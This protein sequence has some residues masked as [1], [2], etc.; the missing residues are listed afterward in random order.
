MVKMPPQGGH[1]LGPGD[2]QGKAERMNGGPGESLP[3]HRPTDAVIWLE[4]VWVFQLDREF[5]EGRDSGTPGSISTSWNWSV[6]IL[7]KQQN[8]PIMHHLVTA[9]FN[10]RRPYLSKDNLRGSACPLQ[11]SWASLMAQLVKNLSAMWETAGSPGFDPWGGKI[12]WRREWLTTPVFW[13]GEFHGLCSPWGCKEL[14]TTKRLS[15]HS[16]LKV[17]LL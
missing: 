16:L 9:H 3:Q 1:L 2:L 14:D 4:E 5:H 7:G 6:L 10:C 15:L 11:Y 12:P 13:L 8:V 17:S